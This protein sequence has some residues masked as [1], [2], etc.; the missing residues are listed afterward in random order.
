MEATKN[1]MVERSDKSIWDKP[2]VS[3]SLSTYDQ[4]RWITA[5]FG[6]ALAMGGSRKGGFGGGVVAMF[7][8]TLAIRAAMGHHDLH[9]ARRWIER[10]LLDRWGSRDSVMDASE[11]SFPASDAPSWTGVSGATPHK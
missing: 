3:S 1:L 2:S 11:E 5:A 7:G 4:E 8:T 6:S 10:T 9:V